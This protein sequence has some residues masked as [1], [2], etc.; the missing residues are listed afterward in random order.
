MYMCFLFFHFFVNMVIVETFPKGTSIGCPKVIVT[1]LADP[2]GV[3][4]VNPT[5]EEDVDS[6]ERVTVAVTWLLPF[7]TEPA[8]MSNLAPAKETPL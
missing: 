7:A 2:S 3:V 8:R 1:G 5:T 6:L 4:M